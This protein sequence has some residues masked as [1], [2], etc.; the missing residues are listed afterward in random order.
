MGYRFSLWKNGRIDLEGSNWIGLICT[1]GLT[2]IWYYTLLV[3]V[4]FVLVENGVLVKW[5]S[6]S[7][8][9]TTK[10]WQ[11]KFSETFELKRTAHHTTRRCEAGPR[12]GQGH[13]RTSTSAPGQALT[14]QT[15]AHHTSLA[16]S[17]YS[18][19]FH[20]QFNIFIFAFLLVT[21]VQQITTHLKTYFS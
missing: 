7:A 5:C 12:C 13:R 6:K 15:Q 20:N 17:I 18:L 3:I 9:S 2:S 1:S 4:L 10:I 19:T 14:R 21:W 11:R 16:Q 8:D